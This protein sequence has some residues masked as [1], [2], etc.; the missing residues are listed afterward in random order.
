MARKPKNKRVADDQSIASALSSPG[1]SSEVNDRSKKPVKKSRHRAPST[2]STRQAPTG[3][4]LD[5]DHVQL[6]DTVTSLVKKINDQQQTIDRLTQ[7]VNFLMTYLG[8]EATTTTT[9]TATAVASSADPVAGPSTS[10]PDVAQQLSNLTFADITAKRPVPLSMAL[11]QAV[12]SAVYKD[13][14]EK[15]RRARNVVIKGL[16]ACDGHEVEVVKAMLSGE[17]GQD[18][19]VVKCRRLGQEQGGKVLPVLVTLSSETE[20]SFVT[21]NARRLRQSNNETVRRS[22]YINPDL[23]RAEA[24]TAYQNRCERRERE[25]K[26]KKSDQQK[27]SSTTPPAAPV[28]GPPPTSTAGANFVMPMFQPTTSMFVPGASTNTPPSSSAAT[29]TAVPT[30]VTATATDQSPVASTA[31]TNNAAPSS[32]AATVTVTATAATATGDRNTSQ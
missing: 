5:D 14:E 30:V 2:E 7:Q 26:R 9:T 15:D 17:L 24:F 4:D 27:S 3:M 12:V 23:T 32:S 10:S 31:N 1:P 21:Q 28:S 6:T 18:F 29:V 22:I 11:K 25:A 8:V 13:F 20:A 19:S 16:P